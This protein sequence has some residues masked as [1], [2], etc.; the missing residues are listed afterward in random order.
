MSILIQAP[1]MGLNSLLPSNMLDPRAAASGTKN[2]IYE[3][4]LLRAAHG[5]SKLDLTTTGLNS[6]EQIQNIFPF[7]ELDGYS[8]L[9]AATNSKLYE[10]DKNNETWTDRTQSGFTFSA[11]ID[12]PFSYA[13]VSHTDG[14]ALNGSGSDWYYH[15]LVCDGGNS[16]IQRWAGRY[17]EDTDDLVGAG[18]YHD[19]T[20]HR[21]LQVASYMSR[22]ILI[23]PYT[24]S[25]SSK[26]WTIQPQRVQYPLVGKLETWA[27]TGSGFNDLLDT[28]GF[29]VRSAM[30]GG[31]HVVY[32]S[33][34]IWTLRHVGG[35]AVFDPYPYVPDL[36]LIA[37]HMLIV[38]NNIHYFMAND[39]NIYSY[40]GG[41]VFRPIGDPIHHYLEEAISKSYEYRC[42]MALDERE[43]RL[44][45]F[46]VADGDNF[47]RYAFG[48]DMRTGAWTKRD[49]TGLFT[50]AETD[51]IT[52]VHLVG[53]Q[54]YTTGETYQNA[55]NLI[56]V[57]AVD[58]T[59]GGTAG[60]ATVRY[61]D[62]LTD[63]TTDYAGDW[64]DVQVKGAGGLE[65]SLAAGSFDDDFTE[66]DILVVDDTAGDFSNISLG[67]HYY[68]I[69]DV[70]GNGF[71]IYPRGR[72]TTVD[73]GIG[74][75]SADAT[76][77]DITFDATA[78]NYIYLLTDPSGDTYRQSVKEFLTGEKLHIGDTDG[79][80][81]QFD[82]DSVE[83][84]GVKITSEHITP[85]YDLQMPDTYKR[86]PGISI[87]AKG[88]IGGSPNMIKNGTFNTLSSWEYSSNGNVSI[89]GGQ[90]VI[91]MNNDSLTYLYQTGISVEAGQEYRLKLNLSFSPSNKFNIAFTTRSSSTGLGDTISTVSSG[92]DID[93]VFTATNDADTL[94][95]VISSYVVSFDD[96]NGSSANIDNIEL[97]QTGG[98]SVY[99]DI[100]DSGWIPT[101]GFL[102]TN[103]YEERPVY[104]NAT[105][106]RIKFK[107]TGYG[108]DFKIR[109]YKIMEPEI[110]DDR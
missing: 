94:Y 15:L 58:V 69:Y 97:Y 13:V 35:S 57:K 26:Q 7:D 44:W 93:V 16:N 72:D 64:S 75:F 102:L 103:Q 36:G 90:C 65:F 22:L 41:S 40:H 49:F 61:G 50:D 37:P 25:S 14:I 30:L 29:N 33:N 4:G 110:E 63:T 54:S 18:G 101:R 74:D 1:T 56:A 46:Y 12:Q 43:E 52:A 60:D 27:G 19:G 31:Q 11:N 34:G 104:I 9:M 51:G 73:Y 42:W 85:T 23:S 28:G 84:S 81:Y 107:F 68:T 45:V 39:Y 108:S 109:E 21:A 105:G 88:A 59:D 89:N 48:M 53:S 71:S 86:W 79:F 55:L 92:D 82:E 17:E 70:S 8:H 62:Y 80:I 106:R 38:K 20:T 99:Y 66:N 95:I 5:F 91:T 47:I 77:V 32:Q 96:A 83:D 10:N 67:R 24:Y 76:G 2:I 87:V 100:D 98:L 6:G 78:K 3:R